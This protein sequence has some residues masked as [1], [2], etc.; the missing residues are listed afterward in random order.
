MKSATLHPVG[1][2]N[3]F[4]IDLYVENYINHMETARY[5]AN[6]IGA[7]YLKFL[8]PFN[9]IGRSKLSRF[10]INSIKHI[11]RR[12]TVGGVSEFDLIV[13]FY[14]RL[15][16]RV[17][18]KEGVFN[19]QYMFEDYNGEIYFDHVHF[20]DIGY[21]MIAKKIVEEIIK[22]EKEFL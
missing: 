22:I 11:Q 6:L 15:W 8:Q 2:Y 7:R 20:S 3:G 21:D 9:G 4:N 10:D 16:Q 5:Y 14:D 18:D 1:R 19:L 17:K 12:I 13:S